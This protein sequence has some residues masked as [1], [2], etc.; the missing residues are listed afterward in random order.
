MKRCKILPVTALAAFILPGCSAPARNAARPPAIPEEL[1]TTAE[2]SAQ[3][4]QYSADLRRSATG[5]WECVLTAPETVA[6]LTYKLEDSSVTLSFEDLEFTVDRS[7]LPEYG[8]VKML[9]ESIDMLITS[10]DL[11]CT[12]EDGVLHEKAIISGL[13]LSAELSGGELTHI[14]VEGCFAAD[15]VQ[16]NTPE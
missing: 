2:F 8:P 4:R 14:E 10:K 1:E 3:G 6:G 16:K 13:D 15:I 12:E 7:D 9:T 5:L 11:T